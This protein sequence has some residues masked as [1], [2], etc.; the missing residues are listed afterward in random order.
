[1]LSPPRARINRMMEPIYDT[2]TSPS[3]MTTPPIS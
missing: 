2:V 1:L 3:D